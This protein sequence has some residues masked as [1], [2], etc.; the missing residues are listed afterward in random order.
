MDVDTLGIH[1]ADHVPARAVFS[2]TVNSLQYDKETMAPVCIE[3][4][5]QHA[6]T[7]E[8]ALEFGLGRLS[9]G[10]FAVGGRVHSSEIDLRTGLYP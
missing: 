4:A 2:G 5:L 6:D 10:P 3:L 9:G 8:I 1:S 7:R